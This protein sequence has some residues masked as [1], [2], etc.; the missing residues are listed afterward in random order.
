MKTREK[1]QLLAKIGGGT[2]AALVCLTGVESAHAVS[3]T[4]TF[5]GGNGQNG[6]MFDVTTFSNDITIN[7]LDI[8]NQS[9]TTSNSLEVYLKNGTY[10]G[11]ETAPG[12]W[13]LVSTTPLTSI[14]PGGTPTTVDVTD[15]TLNANTTYGLYLTL[16]SGTLN[17]TNG[18]NTYTNSDLE[19]QTGVG[20]QYPFDSTFTPR[21]WNGTINYTG[22]AS[23]SVPFEFS[24]ALGLLLAGGLFGGS[25]LYR[26][27][28]AKKVILDREV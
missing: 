7:S 9:G 27:H 24:P 15:F 18:A 28:K 2:L 16:N 19:I 10:V 20:K 8:N 13:T 21:T 3:I 14:Q 5:A 12:D 4:T 17:Y 25:H 1:W 26:Q 11:S 6:N 22:G 23:A